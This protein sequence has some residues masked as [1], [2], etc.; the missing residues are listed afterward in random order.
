[1]ALLSKITNKLE[2]EFEK[3]N[4]TTSKA[5]FRVINESNDFIVYILTYSFSVSK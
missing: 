1:M 5:Y 4:A 3:M 2:Q